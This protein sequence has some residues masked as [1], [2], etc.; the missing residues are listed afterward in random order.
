MKISFSYI[1][2]FLI[3]SS[4]QNPIDTENLSNQIIFKTNKTSY[5]TLDRIDIILNNESNSTI[6]VGLRCGTYLEMLYQ[7]KEGNTWSN[8]L[9]FWYLSLGCLTRADTIE[10]N[11]IF[12][13]SIEPKTFD[14]LGTY[15]LVLNYYY[16]T[17]NID[18]SVFSNSF[19]IK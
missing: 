16:L 5:S 2:L 14:T 4:C 7:K 18:D 19:E 17:K 12:N 8:K 9:A 13:Y 15:R 10:S 3:I 11:T 6:L 1:A